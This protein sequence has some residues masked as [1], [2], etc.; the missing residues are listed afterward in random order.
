MIFTIKHST[1]Q[2]SIAARLPLSY[3]KYSIYAV[4]VFESPSLILFAALLLP[5]PLLPLP[6]LL[7]SPTRI[8]FLTCN[9]LFSLYRH[10]T[11]QLDRPLGLRK[12]NTYDVPQ[13][14][15]Q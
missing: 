12:L 14:E 7:P 11:G 10:G 2:F 4:G 3:L 9:S 6:F 8:G 15:P 13:S 5:L 1:T